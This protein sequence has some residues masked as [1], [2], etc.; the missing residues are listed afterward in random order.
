MG[1]THSGLLGGAVFE[2][3]LVRVF[4][5]D[6]EAMIAYVTRIPVKFPNPSGGKLVSYPSYIEELQLISICQG[7]DTLVHF[8]VADFADDAVSSWDTWV[9]IRGSALD[10]VIVGEGAQQFKG[11]CP[12]E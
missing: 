1:A 6:A 11:T 3:Q 8:W 10:A 9:R 4:K 2:E 12:R 7:A 5:D